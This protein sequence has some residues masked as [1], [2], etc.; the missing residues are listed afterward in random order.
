[1][2]LSPNEFRNA[3]YLDF[4]GEGKKRDGTVPMPH[5]AGFLRPNQKGKSGK[6]TCAFFRPNWKP[7]SN[8]ITGAQCI[9]F[10]RLF[11]D[12]AIELEKK[13]SYLVYWTV[14][15]AMILNQYLNAEIFN[16]LKP[17]LYNLHSPGKKFSRRTSLFGQN[18]TSKDRGLEDFYSAIYPNRSKQPSL[19]RGPAKTCKLIDAACD[20]RGKWKNFS[21]REKKYVAELI[22]YNKG[23]CRSTWLISHKIGNHFKK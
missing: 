18:T 12:L 9:T 7:V 10:D 8:G 22:S 19:S 21:E 20:R 6:Y 17:F 16:K 13:D 1:M 11:S 14:H 15:E 2:M 4:E 3:I 5:M 23:D